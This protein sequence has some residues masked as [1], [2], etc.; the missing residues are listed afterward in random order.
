M[1]KV[2]EQ[3]TRAELEQELRA[4]RGCLRKEQ[5]SGLPLLHKPVGADA[6]FQILRQMTE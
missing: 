4:L 6:V 3:M 2:V 1:T 5:Q